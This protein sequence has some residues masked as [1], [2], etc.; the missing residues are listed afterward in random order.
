[1][2]WY[3]HDL[4]SRVLR[5]DRMQEYV[6]SVE[7]NCTSELFADYCCADVVMTRCAQGMVAWYGRHEFELEHWRVLLGLDAE[8]Q[9]VTEVS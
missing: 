3:C 1:M 5:C 7:H 4:S 9:R 6:V 8:D 2:N